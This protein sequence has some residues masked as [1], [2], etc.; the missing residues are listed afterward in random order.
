MSLSQ[1]T[2]DESQNTSTGVLEICI[3]NAW[4]AVC[5]DSFFGIY[6]AQVA[7]QQAGGYERDVVGEIGSV[8]FNGPVFLSELHCEGEEENVLSCTSYERLGSECLTGE[9]PLITCRG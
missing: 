8:V 4:G 6:D 9:V 1:S 2:E 5:H 7:C 3:N